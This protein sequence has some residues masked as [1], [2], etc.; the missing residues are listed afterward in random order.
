MGEQFLINAFSQN[1]VHKCMLPPTTM[2]EKTTIFE[3]DNDNNTINN[4]DNNNNK[5]IKLGTT[6]NC[7]AYLN[8]V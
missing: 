1:M 7:N 8:I 6:F 3:H 5:S 4:N 2:I